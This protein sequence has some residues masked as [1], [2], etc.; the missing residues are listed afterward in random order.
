LFIVHCPLSSFFRPFPDDAL[1][2]EFADKLRIQA[3][4]VFVHIE[5]LAAFQAEPAL[6]FHADADRFPVRMISAFH[7]I[8]R[9][10]TNDT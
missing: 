6:V 2:P 7:L 9:F 3:F 5:A 4:A 10:L 8:P 1:A